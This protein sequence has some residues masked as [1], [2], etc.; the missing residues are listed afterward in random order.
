MAASQEARL[1]EADEDDDAHL[2]PTAICRGWCGTAAMAR[3]A[4]LGFARGAEEQS[5]IEREESMRNK[6]GER[7]ILSPPHSISGTRG[8]RAEQP[9]MALGRYRDGGQGRPGRFCREPPALF[10]FLLFQSFLYFIFCFLNKTCS[11]TFIWGTKT[12]QKN[13]K[14]VLLESLLNL[15]AQHTIC[16]RFLKSFI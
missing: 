4:R 15:Q 5:E 6:R 11:K 3:R 14:L 7:G 13:M 12:F 16:L 1:G 8:G 2:S 9:A 10:L